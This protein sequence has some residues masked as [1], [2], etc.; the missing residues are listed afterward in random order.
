MRELDLRLE[1][2]VADLTC[3]RSQDEFV[4]ETEV[5]G[6]TELAHPATEALPVCDLQIR[7]TSGEMEEEL[8]YRDGL[9]DSDDVQVFKV[10]GN[11]A[12]RVQHESID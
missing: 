10:H 5:P 1:D 9:D 11:L 8:D 2:R 7:S 3:K 4:L 12:P 6:T